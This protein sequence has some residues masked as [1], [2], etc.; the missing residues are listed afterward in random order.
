[1][2]RLKFIEKIV[3]VKLLVIV[4]LVLK[5]YPSTYCLMQEK[6]FHL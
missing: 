5:H 2:I 6:L 4:I 3:F 1:M